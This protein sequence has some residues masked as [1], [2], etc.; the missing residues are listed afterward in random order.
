MIET[1]PVAQ[2]SRLAR[3]KRYQWYLFFFFPIAILRLQTKGKI[4]RSTCQKSLGFLSP[5]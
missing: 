2:V 3:M 4:D 5:L 1:A